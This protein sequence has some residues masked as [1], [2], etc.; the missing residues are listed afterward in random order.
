[1]GLGAA[2]SIA[3]SS[4]AN[5]S[6]Q[7]SLVSHNVANADTP[8]YVAE[9]A[10]QQSETVDGLGLGVVTGP[11]TREIDTALQAQA[12]QQASTVAGL[13]TTQTALQAIDAVQGTLARAA[14]SPACSAACRTVL[15]L[16]QRSQQ[17]D[18]AGGGG[19]QRRHAGGNH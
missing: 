7:L 14:T 11:V 3:T 18:A 5:V 10:T 1:M 6:S 12:F 4:L 2:L 9:T 19:V 16:A 17:P 15:H 8:G 13:Q